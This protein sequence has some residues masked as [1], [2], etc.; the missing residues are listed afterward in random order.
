MEE[1][2]KTCRIAVIDDV[3]EEAEYIR[4]LSDKYFE[5]HRGYK[6]EID[7]YER[8]ESLVRDIKAGKYYDIY[9]LDVEMP[10]KSGLEIAKEIRRCYPEVFVVFVTNHVQYAIPA[11]EV[12]AFRYIP[13]R[14]LS[15]KLPEAYDHLL[16]KLDLFDKRVY[17]IESASNIEKILYKD[18]YYVTKYSKY[19]T[20]HHRHG[21]SKVRKTLSTI[22]DELDSSEF[23]YIDKGCIVNLIHITSCKK[24]EVVM[25]NGDSLK[26][27][28][29]RYRQ[30]RES[31]MD[32]WRCEE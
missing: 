4:S 26:I 10:E 31:I 7:T 3:A 21:E 2:T 23:I 25:R 11:Y 17:M 18:I 9:L 12:N 22:M 28:R 32:Y 20:I 6:H 29:P 13:K 14:L 30:V 15:E 19:L 27:S 1:Q 16:P 24:E 8:G 5:N